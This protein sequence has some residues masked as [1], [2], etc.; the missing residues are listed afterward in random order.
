MIGISVVDIST[1][2]TKTIKDLTHSVQN[3]ANHF[4]M[5]QN[6]ISTPET[7]LNASRNNLWF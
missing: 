4:I 3:D 1:P 2:S 6:N 7:E 5:S